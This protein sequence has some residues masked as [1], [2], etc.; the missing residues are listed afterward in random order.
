MH[1]AIDAQ[2]RPD[3]LLAPDSGA[4]LDPMK[5]PITCDVDLARRGEANERMGPPSRSQ[6]TPDWPA[7]RPPNKRDP[8]WR[9]RSPQCPA[10]RAL[11]Q[12]GSAP[13][14]RRRASPPTRRRALQPE[15]RSRPGAVPDARDAL[16][17]ASIRGAPVLPSSRATASSRKRSPPSDAL[18]RPSALQSTS[19]T[20][21]LTGA[22]A[23]LENTCA[24]RCS[25]TVARRP[26]RR[27]R[28]GLFVESVLA[29]LKRNTDTVRFRRRVR[30]RVL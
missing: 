14:H 19:G 9:P 20:D 11:C 5:S 25:A 1:Y 27:Q 2:R 6:L 28:V 4:I 22:L 10:P 7:P 21:A 24:H 12:N 3:W 8:F 29:N 16:N 26:A 13:T 30:R 18:V 23:R 17:G 15:V